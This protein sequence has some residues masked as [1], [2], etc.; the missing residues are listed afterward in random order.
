MF[1]IFTSLAANYKQFFLNYLQV[2][3]YLFTINSF[4]KN[5]FTSQKHIRKD[6]QG[7]VYKIS[8]SLMIQLKVII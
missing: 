8:N 5:L 6:K 7:Q 4:N 1:F 3:I 2:K